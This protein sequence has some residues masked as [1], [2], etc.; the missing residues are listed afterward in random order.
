MKNKI[1]GLILLFGLVSF[2]NLLSMDVY[3][4]IFSIN[5]YPLEY[6][7]SQ[8]YRERKAQKKAET[9]ANNI[10]KKRTKKISQL[11]LKDKNDNGS[12]TK[13][14]LEQQFKT[15]HLDY[16]L[17][18]TNRLKSEKISLLYHVVVN[19]KNLGLAYWLFAKGVRTLDV[20]QA[21]TNNYLNEDWKILDTIIKLDKDFKNEDLLKFI[22]G[23]KNNI[24]IR[25]YLNKTLI[26]ESKIYDNQNAEKVLEGFAYEFE[27]RAFNNLKHE[28]WVD[29]EFK[30]Q[31][32]EE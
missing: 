23:S 9:T 6:Y 10:I 31:E 24:L 13:K 18:F 21:D 11:L 32:K 7:F 3:G 2:S 27:N 15:N 29:V 8:K 25:N 28:N 20:C 5:G 22:K 26:D 19:E 16:P 4:V 12:R 1:M 14:Y 30:F 17:L